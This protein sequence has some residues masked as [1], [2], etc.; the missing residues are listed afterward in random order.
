[1][2]YLKYIECLFFKDRHSEVVKYPFNDQT[3]SEL[4]TYGP[5]FGDI[6]HIHIKYTLNLHETK[7]CKKNCKSKAKLTILW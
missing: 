6:V 1:M 7:P 2:S 4:R 3:F 5:T